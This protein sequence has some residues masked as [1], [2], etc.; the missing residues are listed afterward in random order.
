MVLAISL[1]LLNKLL[2]GLLTKTDLISFRF[3][4]THSVHDEIS[5]IPEVTALQG[6]GHKISNHLLGGTTINADILHVHPI[7][8]EE[9]LD[10]G[11]PCG[12]AT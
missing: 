1:A 12:L 4:A 5:Q 10:V 7:C 6:L 11:M 9:V 2:A 3:N 8:D